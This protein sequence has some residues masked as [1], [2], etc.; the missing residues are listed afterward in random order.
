VSFY[1]K[2]VFI[3]VS[4]VNSGRRAEG[5]AVIDEDEEGGG[6]THIKRFTDN[7]VQI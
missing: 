5:V 2:A 6:N 1:K 3:E 4:F 7:D